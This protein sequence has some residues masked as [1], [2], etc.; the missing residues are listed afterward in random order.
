VVAFIDNFA[1]L[2]P[3]VVLAIVS[4]GVAEFA[5]KALFKR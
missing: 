5:Y 4:T 3:A 2:L 1:C